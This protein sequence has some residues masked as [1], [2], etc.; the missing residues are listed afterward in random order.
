MRI[1][2]ALIT[3]MFCVL[4]AFSATAGEPE[5]G[6]DGLSDPIV[7]NITNSGLNWSYQDSSSG[8]T[9]NTNLGSIGENG[10]H[11]IAHFWTGA[12]TSEFGVASRTSDSTVNW[13]IS[14]TGAN[15]QEVTFGSTT[16]YFLISGGDFNGNGTGDAVRIPVGGRALMYVDMFAGGSIIGGFQLPNKSLGRSKAF[17]V[18]RNGL[19]DEIALYYARAKFRKLYTVDAA[20]ELTSTTFPRRRRAAVDAMPIAQSD[21]TDAVLIVE[22]K[23]RKRFVVVYDLSGAV[24]HEA[25]VGNNAT[26]IVGEYMADAGGEY[27]V[28]ISQTGQLTVTN[29]YTA[30]QTQYTLPSGRVLADHVNVFSF[31]GSSGGSGGNSGGGSGGSGGSG[32]LGGACSSIRD[33]NGSDIWKTR[34]SD[35]FSDCRRNTVGYIVAPGGQGASNSCIPVYDSKGNQIYSMGAYSPAGPPWRSRHYGCWGCSN[36]SLGGSSLAAAARKNTGSSTVYLGTSGQQCVRIPDAG[37][38]YNSSSC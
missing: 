28:Y 10:D 9:S 14:D 4:S 27:A 7:I 19:N 35:H 11:V 38:C 22:K 30:A 18:N 15:T 32:S 20:G 17:Y 29:P 23:G 3:L 2:P 34:G 13:Q 25:A 21:G 16:D 24:I 31:R 5:F 26:V 6:N 37:R 33:L 8:Y 36:S 12:Q 1:L